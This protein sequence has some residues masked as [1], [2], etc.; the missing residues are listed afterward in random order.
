METH[1]NKNTDFVAITPDI[2]TEPLKEEW[3]NIFYALDLCECHDVPTDQ[4]QTERIKSFI[5]TLLASQKQSIVK[6]CDQIISEEM[7]M[8]CS[9]DNHVGEYDC[10]WMKTRKEM[11]RILQADLKERISKETEFDT[12][13]IKFL[14][15][16]TIS[17]H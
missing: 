17:N 8:H 6:L 15:N 4:P 9:D 14:F 10:L 1:N 2:S 16:Q 7:E 13:D 5:T 3:E 12:K 11:G